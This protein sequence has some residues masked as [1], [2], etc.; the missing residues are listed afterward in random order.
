[1]S[2]YFTA[3]VTIPVRVAPDYDP[4]TLLVVESAEV[5]RMVYFGGSYLASTSSLGFTEAE[6]IAQHWYG[7]RITNSLFLPA[8]ENLW[9]SNEATT[10]FGSELVIELLVT[11]VPSGKIT[12][13]CS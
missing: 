4:S 5:D 2:T 6:A 1:M 10:G 12:F 13:T 9:F 8:G 3:K 7:D 11:G